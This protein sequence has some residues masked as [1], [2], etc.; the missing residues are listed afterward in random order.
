VAAFGSMPVKPPWLRSALVTTAVT[1]T[2]AA[3]G[4]SASS[5]SA[6]TSSASYSAGQ[7]GVAITQCAI[8][9][10]LIPKKYWAADASA[11]HWLVDGHIVDN[12]SFAQWWNANTG[13]ITISGKTLSAW[14]TQ[15][16]SQQHVPEQICGSTA[17]PT[18]VAS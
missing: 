2:V 18:P 6:P 3:C 13:V 7:Y 4:S 14:Q 16:Y 10:G 15:A 17:M 9:R 5:S 1:V 11:H 12:S 8:D